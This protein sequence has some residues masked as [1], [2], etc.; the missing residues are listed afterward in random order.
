MSLI[1][2]FILTLEDDV[3][4]KLEDG[5]VIAEVAVVA[6]VDDLLGDVVVLVYGLG[7]DGGV[8]LAEPYGTTEQLRYTRLD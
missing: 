2:N 3:S 5:D 6:F 1:R 4:V 8:V 7:G